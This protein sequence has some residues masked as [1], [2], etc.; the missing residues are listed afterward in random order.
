MKSFPMLCG[1]LTPV[2]GPQGHLWADP[3]SSRRE[4]LP[5]WA[6]TRRGSLSR[7][8]GSGRVKNSNGQKN[9]GEVMIHAEI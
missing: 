2:K 6:A 3:T 1:S 7:K 5:I 4:R 9:L 8:V